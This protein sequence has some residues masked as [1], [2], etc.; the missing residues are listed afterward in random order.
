MRWLP[1]RLGDRET[2]GSDELG[3][4]RVLYDLDG[5]VPSE[6][7]ELDHLR[8]YADSRPVRIGNAAADQLQLDIYGEMAS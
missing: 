8:G 6:E 4:L 5:T 3:P 2:H 1:E 7:R